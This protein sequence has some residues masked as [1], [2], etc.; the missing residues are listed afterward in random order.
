[1]NDE[2]RDYRRRF[3]AMQERVDRVMLVGCGIVV[4]IILAALIAAAAH[5][6]GM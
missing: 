1:M 4:L 6:A 3:R 5:F 2:Q